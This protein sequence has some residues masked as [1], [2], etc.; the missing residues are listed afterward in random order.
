MIIKIVDSHIAPG[1][2][3]MVLCDDDGK[4]LPNQRGCEVTN[5][6]GEPTIVTVTLQVDGDRVRFE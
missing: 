5:H 3:A 4:I 6:V 2:R 1:G